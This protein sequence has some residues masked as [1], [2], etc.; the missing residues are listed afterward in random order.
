MY[1]HIFFVKYTVV[2]MINVEELLSTNYVILILAEN[3]CYAG[4]LLRFVF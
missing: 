1:V 4:S 3:N 2:I